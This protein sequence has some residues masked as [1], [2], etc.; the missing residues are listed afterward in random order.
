MRRHSRRYRCMHCKATMSLLGA[1]LHLLACAP[2]GHA[3]YEIE[4]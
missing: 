2:F 3:A 1:M 4:S